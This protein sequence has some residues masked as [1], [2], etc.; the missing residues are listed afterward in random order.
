MALLSL[1]HTSPSPLR[2]EAPGPAPLSP[3]PVPGRAAGRLLSVDALRGFTMLWLIGGRE[4]ALW[5]VAW[6]HPPW[7]DAWK[8]QL[9][10]PR[11][12]G[13]VAWDLVMPVFLFVTGAA[14]PLAMA[15]RRQAAAGQQPAWP[16]IARR[17]AV[18]WMLGML[19]QAAKPDMQGLELYS[20]TLQAIAVGYLATSLALARLR[21]RGQVVLLVLLL[22][23]YAALLQFVPF[24]GHAAGVLERQHNIALF[25]DTFVLGSLRRDH[26][27]AWILPSFGF[28]AMVLLGALAGRLLV[29]PLAGGARVVLFAGA[30]AACMAAGWL[31]S[32]WLP[33]NR[34]LW[35]GSLVLWAGGIGLW[36]LAL[37]HGVIDLGRLRGWAFPLVVIGANALLAY[38]ADPVFM[39]LGDAGAVFLAGTQGA[40]SRFLSPFLEF[41]GLWLVLWLLYRRGVFFRA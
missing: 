31:W 8:T 18:L 5:L 9:T 40:A 14:M 3:A 16:R 2:H 26:P 25:I 24:P 4:L 15:G 21:L 7:S 38:A 29:A 36:L 33:M 28:A 23:G 19:I 41:T 22:A 37:F 20:N 17:V 10:H 12:H 11:W 1:F 32:G 34:Y 6:L 35:T 13:P 27:F 30:G 39:R